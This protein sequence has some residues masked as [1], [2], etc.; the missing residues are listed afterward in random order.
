MESQANRVRDAD[1]TLGGL[2]TNGWTS[3]S[4]RSDK[5]SKMPTARLHPNAQMADGKQSDPQTSTTAPKRR[6]LWKRLL[7]FALWS[8][9]SLIVLVSAVIGG[10]FWKHRSIVGVRPGELQTSVKPGELGRWVNPFVGTGGFPWVCG[11]N[12]PGAMVPL[13]KV[14]LGPETVSWLGHKR[15]LNSSGYFY[16]DDQILGFSHTRLN[17]TG[18]TDGGHFFGDARARGS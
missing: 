12:F 3:P 13:G 7:K 4:L 16:G 1:C 18:A 17:G 15:A 8:A 6:P 14:R 10:L 11:N 2:D 5:C 9:L